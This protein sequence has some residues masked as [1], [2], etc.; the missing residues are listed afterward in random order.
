MF[1][2]SYASKAQQ[3]SAWLLMEYLD[4]KSF[5]AAEMASLVNPDLAVRTS[6]THTAIP[7]VPASLLTAEA[8][9]EANIE[10]HAFPPT[11]VFD[12][13]QNDYQIA[14]SDIASGGNVQKE[15]AFAAQGQDTAFKQA[16]LLK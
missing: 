6:L 4:S 5:L 14:I 11:A 13:S 16:G 9:V 2:N 12:A 3:D 8:Y 10:P 15:L 1:L 7:G